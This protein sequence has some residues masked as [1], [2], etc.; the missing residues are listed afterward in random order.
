M[1]KCLTA[2]EGQQRY[3]L[4]LYVCTAPRCDT[5][6]QHVESMVPYENKIKEMLFIS[7]YPGLSVLF[8][9]GYWVDLGT[10]LLRGYD[11]EQL[12]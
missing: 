4:D 7:R 12:F 3:C 11:A 1:G 5:I 2:D 6:G 9:S 8:A 10:T